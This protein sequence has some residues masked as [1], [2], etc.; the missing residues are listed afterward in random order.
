M[1]SINC[2][3]NE[4]KV[5]EK[6]EFD[7]I[8]LGYCSWWEGDFKSDY[9]AKALLLNMRSTLAELVLL[10]S[11][12]TTGRAISIET[13]AKTR[14]PVQSTNSLL[15]IPLFQFPMLVAFVE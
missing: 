15:L 9:T 10:M 12:S 4:I 8:N 7:T 1:A 14:Q 3:F 2:P 13:M 6:Q 5:E 11:T